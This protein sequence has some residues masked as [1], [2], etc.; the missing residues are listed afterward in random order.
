ME[1]YQDHDLGKNEI[2]E[3]LELQLGEQLHALI[4]AS[5]ALSVRTAGRFDPSI[6]PAAFHIIRWLYSYGPTSAAALAESTA[7]DRSSVSRLVKQLETLGY[8]NRE[9]SPDDG[10]GVLLSLTELGHQMTIHALKEK[11]NAFYERISNWNNDQLDAFITMLRKFNG[12][13]QPHA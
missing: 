13:D 1:H 10:R 3:Q 6:Q 5:H 9:N 11:E 8:V 12:F 7:M 4:S 2:R